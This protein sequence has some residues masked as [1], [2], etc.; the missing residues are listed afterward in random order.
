MRNICLI[1]L[2]LSSLLACKKF[3]EIKESVTTFNVPYSFD[4]KIPGTL[5]VAGPLPEITLP[6]PTNS[7]AVF[8]SNNTKPEYIEDVRLKSLNLQIKNPPSA[9]FNF[10]DSI[11]VFITMD[12]LGSG[13][14]LAYLYNVPANVSQVELQT[15]ENKLDEYL[16]KEKFF[17]RVKARTK[18][19]ISQDIDVT[20]N[21]IFSVRAK[22]L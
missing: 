16:K 18:E 8:S 21:M 22:V 9:N 11:E 12:S 3:Q 10:L 4:F 15:T 2:I 5:P 14:R 1:V 19:I 13:E 7:S 6:V 17:I 20:A